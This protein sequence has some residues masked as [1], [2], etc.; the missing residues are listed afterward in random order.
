[1]HESPINQAAGLQ[2]LVQPCGP[3]IMAMVNHGDESAELPLLWRLCWTLADLGYTVTVLDATTF[4]TES[5]P[6]LDQ[7]LENSYWQNEAR[8]E[9]PAWTVVPSGKAIQNLCT[10][11][12]NQAHNLRRLG[13]LFARDSVVI[14]YSRAEWLVPMVGHCGV[15][16]L[17][18]VSP[19]KA[20]LLTSYRALKRLLINGRLEPTIVNMVPPSHDTPSGM[21]NA[22]AGAAS[23]VECARN[24][25]NYDAKAINLPASE[26][27]A[28]G[29]MQRLAL[30][31]MESAVSLGGDS[32]TMGQLL[33]SKHLT[34]MDRFAGSH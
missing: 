8:A 2:G 31:L 32:A 23:L 28:S 22:S 15:A 11:P 26:E 10:P 34:G 1:M 19:V 16:P 13:Q 5:N 12:S 4:E 21:P 20:S 27:H 3:R 18:A 7:L 9:T 17:L 6:G 14:L 25:L 29:A 33:A 30:R 24:F